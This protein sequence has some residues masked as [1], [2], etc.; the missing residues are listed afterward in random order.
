MGIVDVVGYAV[1]LI[2]PGDRVVVTPNIAC[3]VCLNCIQGDTNKCLTVNPHGSGA[4]YGSAGYGGAQAE[5]LK[6]PY[7]DMACLKLPG[8]PRDELEDDFVLLADILPTAYLQQNLLRLN[9]EDL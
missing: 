7:G 2:K 8:K 3:G 4:T 1:K 6:V 5:F 9:P